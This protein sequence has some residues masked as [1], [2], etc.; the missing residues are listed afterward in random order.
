M[1]L[2]TCSLQHGRTFA[3]ACQWLAMAVDEV[4]RHCGALV[5]HVT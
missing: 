3:E 1:P 2:I 5:Q 4:Q